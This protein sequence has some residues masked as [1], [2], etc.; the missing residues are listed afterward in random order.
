MVARQRQAGC[1]EGVLLFVGRGTVAGDGACFVNAAAYD[2]IKTNKA[3][4]A[5][6]EKVVQIKRRM[7]G[8]IGPTI[9]EVGG[10]SG[11][12]AAEQGKTEVRIGF[13][14]DRAN[15]I[16]VIVEADGDG[17]PAFRE[18]GKVRAGNQVGG[19][20]AAV[21]RP[22]AG[23]QDIAIIIDVAGGTGVHH[24]IGGKIRQG[25][26]GLQVFPAGT[27]VNPGY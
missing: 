26:V 17:V 27:V 10:H 19:H 24:K 13:E 7:V 21:V 12:G 2:L 14:L 11:V 1:Q 4:H 22:K 3:G 8:V 23:P 18:K 5:S 25:I 9:C 15:H 6:R 20:D 16:T